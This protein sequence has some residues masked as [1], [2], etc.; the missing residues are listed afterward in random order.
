VSFQR[1]ITPWFC[2]RQFHRTEI[3]TQGPCKLRDARKSGADRRLDPLP[4]SDGWAPSEHRPK[5]KNQPADLIGSGAEPQKAVAIGSLS[6]RQVS[7][8]VSSRAAIRPAEKWV[9]VKSGCRPRSRSC[10]QH[11]R[12][13]RRSLRIR[14]SGKPGACNQCATVPAVTPAFSAIWSWV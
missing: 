5:L 7:G 14:R 11:A 12:S 3:A 13:R 8:G 2:N 10:R 9:R 4:H 6:C 1:P